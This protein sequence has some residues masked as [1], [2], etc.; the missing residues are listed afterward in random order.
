MPFSAFS[1]KET[2]MNYWSMKVKQSIQLAPVGANSGCP[3]EDC[4][5]MIKKKIWS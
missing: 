5:Q 4:R 1:E 3:K 2:M